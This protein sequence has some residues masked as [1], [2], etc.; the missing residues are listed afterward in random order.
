MRE[1]LAKLEWVED[2]P[3]TAHLPLSVAQLYWYHVDT[4]KTLTKGAH[5]SKSAVAKAARE[6][7]IEAHKK[8]AEAFLSVGPKNKGIRKAKQLRK[9]ALLAT[10]A[11]PEE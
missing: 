3:E 9:T 4:A 8:A 2:R 11:I 1:V 5:R 7:A 6:K 10:R